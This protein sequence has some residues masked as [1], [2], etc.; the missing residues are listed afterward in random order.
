MGEK[1]KTPKKEEKNHNSIES[2]DST[3]NLYR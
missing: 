3:P 1:P 2:L